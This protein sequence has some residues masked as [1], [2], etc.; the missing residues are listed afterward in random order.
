LEVAT[1]PTILGYLKIPGFNRYLQPYDEDNVIG[2]GRDESGNVKISL[3]DVTNVSSPKNISE[4]KFEGAWSDT[5]A[6]WDHKAFLFAHTKDLLAI[7]VSISQYTDHQYKTKQSLFIFN[8][9]V[10]HGFVLRGNI[11]HQEQDINDWD[12]S[13]YVKRALY[14]ENVLY[15]ISYK[16]IKLNNLENLAFLKEIL[17]G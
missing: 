3:F 2:L 1:T 14:I 9:T 17:L 15:T 7:P 5:P 12:T 6:L 10:T 4:Y 11:T 8:I 13:Y 16:K